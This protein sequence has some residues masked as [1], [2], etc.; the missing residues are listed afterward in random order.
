MGK[1][2]ARRLYGHWMGLVCEFEGTESERWMTLRLWNEVLK[3]SV[4]MAVEMAA[5]GGK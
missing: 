1:W 3:V 5:T 4:E 2:Q